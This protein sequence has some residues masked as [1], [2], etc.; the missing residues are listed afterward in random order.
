MQSNPPRSPVATG[1][2][3]AVGAVLCS[4]SVQDDNPCC[5]SDLDLAGLLQACGLT[6]WH[7][8]LQE[9]FG[10]YAGW[11]SHYWLDD[12]FDL[13]VWPVADVI[14][15][16]VRWPVSA[17]GDDLAFGLALAEC[18]FLVRLAR[19]SRSGRAW[20]PLC[21]SYR[22]F[23]KTH[24]A[25]PC[26]GDTPPWPAAEFAGWAVARLPADRAARAARA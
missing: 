9:L 12:R 7:D 26:W 15:K 6:H 22:E 17:K 8:L 21:Q 1:G 14:G 18:D 5:D 19:D 20:N 25:E 2:P 11:L 24:E 16:L 10:R 4:P 13:D 3:A 23:L